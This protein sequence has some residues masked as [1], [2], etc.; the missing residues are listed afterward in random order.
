MR[1]PAKHLQELQ[2]IIHSIAWAPMLQCGRSQTFFVLAKGG[3]SAPLG[4]S[5]ATLLTV[6][7]LPALAAPLRHKPFALRSMKLAECFKHSDASPTSGRTQCR[8]TPAEC[9]HL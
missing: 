7:C 5:P 3:H 4:S 8:F 2:P 9:R 6:M 1:W